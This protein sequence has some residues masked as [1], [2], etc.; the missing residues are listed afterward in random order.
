MASFMANNFGL[1]IIALTIIINLI[2]LPMTLGQIRSSKA[3]Q[4][5]QPKLAEL[6]KKYGKDKQK[7]AQEQMALYKTS[8]VK[9]SGCAIGML[10]Q[11]PIWIALYQAILLTL[12]VAPE[13][14][15]NLSRFLYP[16]DMVYSAIPLNSHFLWFNLAA[17]NNY[18]LAI[19]VGAMMWVQNKMTMNANVGDPR[20]ASQ[21]QMMQWMMPLMFAVISISVPSGLALYWFVNSL[22]RVVLQYKITG[23]GGLKKSAP[24]AKQSESKRVSFD[25]TGKDRVIDGTAD[26][27]IKDQPGY[28]KP[29]ITRYL[30]GRKKRQ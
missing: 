25:K 3:M 18:I 11:M 2:L 10:I 1:A 29:G 9:F 7:L 5:L 13:G 12:A 26:I 28:S 17:S 24:P 6:Q 4:D 27:I 20:A 8:G 19:L 15:V 22:F 23:W 16:W 14:L 30:P 21:A